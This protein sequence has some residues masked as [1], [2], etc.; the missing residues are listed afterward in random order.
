MVAA[1]D[2]GPFSLQILAPPGR[3]LL[4]LHLAVRWRT[5][6]QH[7]MCSS[8]DALDRSKMDP[9]GAE[10][11]KGTNLRWFTL[12]CFVVRFVVCC[13]SL[14]PSTVVRRK[15]FSTIQ[16]GGSPAPATFVQYFL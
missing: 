9:D 16:L 13:G 4:P 11:G 8:R 3:L 1:E 10:Q 2:A 12:I 7:G 6:R 5:V 14:V 15:K